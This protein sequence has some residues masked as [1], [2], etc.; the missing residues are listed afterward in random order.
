MWRQVLFVGIVASLLA[1]CGSLRDTH[2]RLHG[3]LWIQTS[4]EYRI[5]TKASYAQAEDALD[6]ALA[7][8]TWTAALEQTDGFQSLPPAIIMDLD[9]TV[10]DNSP[11]EGRLVK[12]RTP[13]MRDKWNQWVEEAAAKALP[14]ALEFI[15]HAQEKD[16]TVFFVTNR[17]MHH[18]HHTR[19][20]LET[21]GITLP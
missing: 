17:R 21:L 2:E 8:R 4:A 15:A 16:V 3:V 20:N 7:D 13:F 5:L 6:R 18:E 12:D 10:L 19:K 1:G 14:G 11:F 9:E